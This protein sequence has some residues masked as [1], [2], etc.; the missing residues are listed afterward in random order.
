MQLKVNRFK[1]MEQMGSY[2]SHG[3][4]IADSRF[5]GLTAVL[6]VSRKAGPVRLA[7]GMRGY[8]VGFFKFLR[9]GRTRTKVRGPSS[10]EI[11]SW[12]DVVSFMRYVVL[13]SIDFHCVHLCVSL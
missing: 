1:Q 10:M 11:V 3:L 13:V 5:H 2:W 9:E 7:C 6:S 12:Q 8:R 4:R